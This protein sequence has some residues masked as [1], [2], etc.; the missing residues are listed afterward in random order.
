ED[1]GWV[2]GKGAMKGVERTLY[3]LPE[4]LAADEVAI[5]E[6]EKDADNLRAAGL[7]ATT[8]VEGAEKWQARFAA[9]LAGKRAIV[10]P[11]NDD[12]GR[13][14]AARIAASLRGKAASV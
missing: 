14:H 10:I 4:V 13:R 1:G 5:V 12:A 7:V 9:I 8:N 3:G 6:G 11:D 2:G